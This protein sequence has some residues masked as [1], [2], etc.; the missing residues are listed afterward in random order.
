MISLHEGKGTKAKK[1]PERAFSLRLTMASCHPKIWRRLLVRES[2]WLARL[3][4]TVQV[5]FDWFDYQ[6]HVFNL[7]DLRMGNPAKR[8][9]LIVEDDRDVALADLD[10]ETRHQFTYDYHFGEGWQV[11]I[12]VEKGGVVERS[13]VRRQCIA[14]D[15]SSSMESQR[16]P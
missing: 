6:T 7:D 9:D 1:P 14:R 15:L 10:L 2:M 11:E 8:E 5:A 12:K 16:Y 3:H 4:D 13:G